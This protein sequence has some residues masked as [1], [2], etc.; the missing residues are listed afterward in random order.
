ME[1]SNGEI[2]IKTTLVDRAHAE[3][4]ARGLL[5]R[6]LAACVSCLPGALSLYRW[7]SEEITEE[8][9]YMI[10]IK[11]HRTKLAEIEAYFKDE[12]PYTVPELLVIDIAGIDPAYREWMQKEMRTSW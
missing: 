1:K 7:E 11:T 9:E 5:T 4:F 2:I 6:R 12:H 3:E 10:W 8:T